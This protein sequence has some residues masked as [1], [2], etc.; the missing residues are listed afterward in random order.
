MSRKLYGSA[1]NVT[2][3][4]ETRLMP[5]SLKV[6]IF[7]YTLLNPFYFWGSGLPQIS[8][9]ILLFIISWAFL[10]A[11]STRSTVGKKSTGP[12]SR[13]SYF[14][15]LGL[16]VYYAILVNLTWAMGHSDKSSF[17]RNSLFL[18]FNFLTFAS[19]TYIY[20]RFRAEFSRFF[21]LALS[22]SLSIQALSAIIL[23]GSQGQR[24]RLFF[25]NPNQLGYF[26]LLCACL[27]SVLFIHNSRRHLLHVTN[28]FIC[29]FLTAA[30]LSRGA[31]VATVFVVICSIVFQTE[32]LK[33]KLRFSI[34]KI[35]MYLAFSI[36]SLLFLNG[37]ISILMSSWQERAQTKGLSSGEGLG[38]RGYERI[39]ENV[40]YWIF[41]AGEGGFS[42][43]DTSMELHSLI[44]NI[45]FSYGLIGFALF[46][47]ALI[48][49]IYRH[50]SSLIVFTAVMLYSFSHNGLRDG[51]FWVLIALSGAAINGVKE[52][53]ILKNTRTEKLENR[54]GPASWEKTE[55]S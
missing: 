40:E 51:F 23:L 55:K 22:A 3:C 53:G 54:I 43:F 9:F 48:A 17:L 2:S 32:N 35:G 27:L 19:F 31:I 11:L 5:A 39:V 50:P 36:G 25:N 15:L 47:S 20:S 1:K 28:L 41:G 12:S 18:L 42:R 49:I 16:F 4:S 13:Q 21:Y 7:S 10:T 24:T 26:A 38:D 6:L 30:S 8:D 34:K 44:G 46:F 52:K 29:V 33:L 37:P 14:I 45:Y